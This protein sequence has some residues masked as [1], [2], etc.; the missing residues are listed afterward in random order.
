M[1]PPELL[2]SPDPPQALG[3]HKSLFFLLSHFT[4]L[5]A[6]L[7]CI[8]TQSCL[9]ST[10]SSSWCRASHGFSGPVCL[11]PRLSRWMSPRTAG[12]NHAKLQRQSPTE[13]EE[14]MT[15]LTASSKGSQQTTRLRSH[16]AQP[17]QPAPDEF[18]LGSTRASPAFDWPDSL[19]PVRSR[20]GRG[21]GVPSER[22]FRPQGIASLPSA[23]VSW[24]RRSFVESCRSHFGGFGGRG[25]L[26]HIQPHIGFAAILPSSYSSPNFLPFVLMIPPSF[27]PLEFSFS[28]S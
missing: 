27:F 15:R 24:S 23:D 26:S 28:F 10:V 21:G 17:T 9:S 13:R 22:R 19:V 18:A 11:L 20:L 12:Y 3:S 6:V 1:R 4:L 2:L 14:G 5:S 16:A 7:P 8:P 25:S